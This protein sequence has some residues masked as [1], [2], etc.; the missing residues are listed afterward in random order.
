MEKMVQ[1][2][3]VTQL[4]ESLGVVGFRLSAEE[5]QSLDDLTAWQVQ[6]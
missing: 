4:T 6:Q 5:K 1:T 2:N 3:N